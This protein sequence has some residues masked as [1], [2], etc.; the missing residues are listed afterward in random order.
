MEEGIRLMGNDP[1]FG[2]IL[3][4]AINA[5]VT[6]NR[7]CQVTT[8]VTVNPSLV[9]RRQARCF[10]PSATDVGHRPGSPPVLPSEEDGWTSNPPSAWTVLWA[11]ADATPSCSM[12]VTASPCRPPAS[13]GSSACVKSRRISRRWISAHPGGGRS[14]RKS[15]F[16]EALTVRRF[17]SITGSLTDPKSRGRLMV[18]DGASSVS[19]SPRSSVAA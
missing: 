6:S 16:A 7:F 5:Q 14:E 2:T 18:K 13:I 1:T 15:R 19:S 4:S 9:P 12:D 11:P 3:G 17:R 8:N 10:A